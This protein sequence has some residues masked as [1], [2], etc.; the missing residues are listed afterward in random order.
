MA[1][2]NKSV[3]ITLR[4]NLKQLEE[5]LKNIPNMTKKE[6]QA[7]TRSLASEFNKAQ[8][9]AKKAA[10]ESKKAAKATSA[11]YEQSGK[12]VGASFD[13]VAQDAKAAAH[14]VKI[15][16]EDAATESN[17]LAE[18]AE[19]LGTSMGAA[20]LA[21][22]KLIPGLDEGAKKA[23]EMADGVATAAEQAIKGG[24]A[25]MILTAAVVAG[26]AAYDLMTRAA[27]TN[28]RTT[29]EQLKQFA[30]LSQEIDKATKSALE[31]SKA[32][33]LEQI[34]QERD[35]QREIYELQ[36]QTDLITGRI[37]EKQFK[38][39][40][41]RN[42][43]AA[44]LSDIG[45]DLFELNRQRQE[46]IKQL[47]EKLVS[48]EKERSL[49][50]E[51]R[52][53]TQASEKE[54][55]DAIT[56]QEA[57]TKETTKTNEA[58]DQLNK[59]IRESN[60]IRSE[61][62]R[63]VRQRGKLER[64]AVIAQ[65]RKNKALEKE[66]EM[67]QSLQ[68]GR[69]AIMSFDEQAEAARQASKDIMVSVLP[70]DE[71]IAIKAQ[72]QVEAK[73]KQIEQIEAQLRLMQATAETEEQRLQLAFA[74]ESA[75]A[76][77]TEIKKEQALIEEEGLLKISELREQLDEKREKAQEKISEDRRKQI[78]D[79][80][81]YIEMAN[82]AT[83]GTFR[84]TTSAIGE[85]IKITGAEN[86]NTVRALFEMNK[87]AAIGEIGFNTAKAITAAQAYPPPF[88]GLMIASAI[89]AGAAQGAVVMSQQPPQFHMGGMTPDE[90]IAV[91]KAGEAVLDRA[92]VDRLGGEPGVNRLQNGQTGQPEVIVM[93]PYK[94]FDRYM[95]DRQ[96]AGL[97]SRSARRGY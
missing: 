31:F 70:V 43:E 17:Q 29:R 22:D 83:I 6:A 57:I 39:Q 77:I 35:V 5:G 76:A 73:Q 27:I 24:P 59:D 96:R 60:T 30:G 74:E 38:I 26:A 97:S 84:N 12:K 44:A 10:E 93:N 9:A 80:I 86:A 82:E 34:F 53:N 2:V 46:E 90:S 71:Q 16:F 1:D 67:Q 18:G 72:E 41:S 81:R 51:I 56:R 66:K 95:T 64:A 47:E 19:T 68:E 28:L 78:D 79:D 88:N 85:L 54:K 61:T 36:L 8:K 92:T 91:V 37:S 94:H 23:L 3:E 48:L 65:E 87:V 69:A 52:R 45:T 15:S 42:K 49:L 75:A 11:A 33:R 63:A 58:I 7:M 55:K 50:N 40:Q 20:T 32:Q 21:V 14:E 13:K 4:A 89:A 62:E 25:T